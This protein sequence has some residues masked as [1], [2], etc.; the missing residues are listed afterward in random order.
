M[1]NKEMI[2]R[3]LLKYAN[4][5][6]L[7][8]MGKSKYLQS[9][10]QLLKTFS[11][12][13]ILVF[14]T[15]TT[16]LF[17]HTHQITE[18]AAEVVDGDTFTVKDSFHRK[19]N[20]TEKTFARIKCEKELYEKDP[21]IFGVEKCLKMNGYNPD[22]PELRELDD[23]L[24]EFYDFCEKH[25]AIVVGQ[26]AT[27]DLN[28]V[29]TSLKKIRPGTEIKNQG[30]YDTKVF[31][32]TFVIPALQALKERGDEDT[33]DIIEAIWDPEK[34]RPSSRLGLILKAFGINIVGWHGAPA[35]VKSTVLALKKIMD[36][37]RDHSDIVTD[38]VFQK[39]RNKAFHKEVGEYKARDKKQRR[40]FYRKDKL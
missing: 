10:E 19:V 32:S 15:E 2:Q 13:D 30:V 21:K 20:L 38:P 7:S 34:K 8:G 9:P 16:G 24:I 40:D 36:F 23:V 28:M 1:D 25:T 35:D 29:N 22:D 3:V 5:T 31:F 17:S 39:E 33:K 12:K 14:D 18:I 6:I 11:G 27:F 26:N 4:E 37:I